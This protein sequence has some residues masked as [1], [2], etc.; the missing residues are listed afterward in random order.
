M[1]DLNPAEEMQRFIFYVN[2]NFLTENTFRML[3][4]RKGG[5]GSARFMM[6]SVMGGDSAH[7]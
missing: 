4:D 1:V 7:A 5:S 6:I 3:V 2:S